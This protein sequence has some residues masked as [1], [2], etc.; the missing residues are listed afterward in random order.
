MYTYLL[1]CQELDVK[2]DSIQIVNKKA[3]KCIPKMSLTIPAEVNAAVFAHQTYQW[4]KWGQWAF[5]T[6]DILT[7]HRLVGGAQMLLVFSNKS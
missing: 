5:F 6:A 2:I 3:N 7:C 1:S 4:W